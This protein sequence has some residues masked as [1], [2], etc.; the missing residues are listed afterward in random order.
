MASPSLTLKE[1]IKRKE[2]DYLLFLARADTCDFP[3]QENPLR[4][5]VHAYERI[6]QE[7]VTPKQ[8]QRRV[9]ENPYRVPLKLVDDQKPTKK[10][11]PDPT[12]HRSNLDLESNIYDSRHIDII[13]TAIKELQLQLR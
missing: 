13:E 9:Q 2:E 4:H 6:K 10:K 7:S 1:V 5:I 12:T 3:L 8:R 11:R